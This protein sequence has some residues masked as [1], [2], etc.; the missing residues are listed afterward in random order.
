MASLPDF[1]PQSIFAAPRP[2][3]QQNVSKADASHAPTAAR[4]V[5]TSTASWARVVAA[6][7]KLMRSSKSG[8]GSPVQWAGHPPRHHFSLSVV[9]QASQLEL[10][11]SLSRCLERASVTIA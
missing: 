7:S 5:A 8:P 1:E 6:A 2:P 11:A 9:T 3:A 4:S 10:V